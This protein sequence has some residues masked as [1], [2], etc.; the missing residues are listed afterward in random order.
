[1]DGFCWSVVLGI[2]GSVVACAAGAGLGGQSSPGFDSDAGVRA[3]GSLGAGG[4]ATQTNAANGGSHASSV[5]SHPDGVG[6][7]TGG[8]APP[9]DD[10][11]SGGSNGE[12]SSTDAGDGASVDAAVA[13]PPAGMRV[14]GYYPSWA[15]YDRNFQVADVHAELLTHLNYAFANVSDTGECVLG[16][17]WADV[18]KTFDGDDWQAQAND[19]AG[20]FNQLRKLKATHPKLRTLIS[21]GGWTWSAH[22]SDV[23]LTADSRS[24]FAQ[25]CAAFVNTYGFDGL[26][27]DWEYPVKGGLD[28]NTQRPEDAENYVLLL[29]ALRS[30]LDRLGDTAKGEHHLLTI[31]SS[32]AP[33]TFELLDL[34]R[35]ASPLDGVNLMTYDFNGAWAPFVAHDA[36]LYASPA[37]TSTDPVER[38]RFNAAAA[39]QSYLGA[40]VPASKIAMGVPF[41]GH[42]FSGV[43][44]A[45]HG[46]YQSATGQ[47][48]NGTWEPGSF[49]YWDLAANYV[50]KKDFVRYWDDASKVPY[51]YSA[52]QSEFISYDD[53]ESLELK[54]RYARAQ[55]LGGVMVW[56][57]SSDVH[58]STPLLS[59]L[60]KGLEASP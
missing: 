29:Q 57:L 36:P 18:Q 22:F 6:G 8:V 3:S 47:P 51:L 9:V 60:V 41:Y 50:G 19:Q 59:A 43:P 1:M 32:A 16:D 20:N 26:D 42:G 40:G 23:A 27:V 13:S 10:D 11:A 5:Q 2:S 45:N 34:A 54:G 25:S 39:V 58:D 24:H 46:L 4:T 35:V 38:S 28:G 37:D 7:A 21:V 17:P 31:A 15:I 52:S 55:G 56:D 44:A 48:P 49:D 53:P 14:V 33:G 12:S 30:E